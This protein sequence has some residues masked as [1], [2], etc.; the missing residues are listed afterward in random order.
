MSSPAKIG[1]SFQMNTKD[2]LRRGVPLGQATRRATDFISKFILG[3]T[4]GARA[5]VRFNVRSCEELEEFC[6]CRR[7]MSQF[8]VNRRSLNTSH[9][10]PACDFGRWRPCQST[11]QE[12]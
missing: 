3:D 9:R 10:F 5:S 12:V 11:G 2:F 4:T 1:D 6:D 7:T 8:A